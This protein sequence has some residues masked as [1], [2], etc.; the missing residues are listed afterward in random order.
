[1]GLG[2]KYGQTIIPRTEGIDEEKAI[3]KLSKF[4]KENF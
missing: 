3:D 4:F 2:A 1:M